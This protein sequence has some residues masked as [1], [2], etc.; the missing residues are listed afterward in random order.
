MNKTKLIRRRFLAGL[1]IAAATS[2]GA[3]AWAGAVVNA[4]KGHRVPE[5]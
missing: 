3:P 1:S 2:F 4:A 5:L